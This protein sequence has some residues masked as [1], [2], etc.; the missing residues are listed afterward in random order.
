MA[1][2]F[3]DT[4]V[5]LRHLTGTPTDQA[6][7]ATAIFTRIENGE[8][9]VT[10][11]D[12][13]VFEIVYTLQRTYELSRTEIADVLMPLLELSNITLPGK[14]QFREV[15]ELFVSR[16]LPFA[17]AYFAVYMKKRKFTEIISFDEHFDNIPGVIRIIP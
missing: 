11:S 9:R 3:L 17:V 4:N 16:N 12:V 8:L 5:F 1:L 14:K 13:V 15:F 7:R 2:P 6:G 10:T